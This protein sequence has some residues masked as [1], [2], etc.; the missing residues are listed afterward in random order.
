M[1]QD[2]NDTTTLGILGGSGFYEIE[3]FSQ[4]EEITL[5]TP[6]GKPSGPFI[7]GELNG[8]K[9]AFLPRHG[10]GHL[11]LPSEINYRANIFGFKTLGVS[12]LISVT[13]VGSL[14]ENIAPLDM[15][16][17]DQL[18]DRTCQRPSTFFGEG[19]AAHVSFAQPFCPDLSEILYDTAASR[20]VQAHQTG[21]LVT[22]EGPMFST[23]AESY[24]YRQ[25]GCDII[26]MTT[27]QEARLAREA[28]IC[29]A[30][31]AM[32]TDYDCWK[33]NSEHEVTVETVVAHM[34]KNLAGAK[35]ILKESVT[36]IRQTRCCDCRDSLAGA[37]MT[38]PEAISEQT[39]EKL[40]PLIA[41]RIPTA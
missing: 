32:V 33:D 35:E 8:V 26:G 14:Q 9:T 36:K 23:K 11:Y 1:E 6:F 34:A 28:E 19:I 21:T 38:S 24:L 7:L 5:A 10:R 16:V 30:A 12:H 17:P 25:W 40:S 4:L 15:V 22:I 31:L 3:G 39:R 18:V 37:I 41:H 2:T 29:F 20:G 13:A 27:L